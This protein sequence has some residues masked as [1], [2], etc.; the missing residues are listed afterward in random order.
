MECQERVLKGIIFWSGFINIYIYNKIS[1]T[2]A[3]TFYVGRQSSDKAC[4]IN[5]LEHF[6][7]NLRGHRGEI[8][9]IL[10]PILLRFVQKIGNI[11]LE[12]LLQ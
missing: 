1:I 5:F 2:H 9:E 3:F 12:K 11:Y 10:L 6:V 7:Y 4:Q 8:M